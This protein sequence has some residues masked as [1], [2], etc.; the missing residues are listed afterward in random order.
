MNPLTLIVALTNF[1]AASWHFYHGEWKMAVVWMCYSVSGV[2][3]A[4][5]K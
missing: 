4:F 5:V 3:L 2:M 1:L